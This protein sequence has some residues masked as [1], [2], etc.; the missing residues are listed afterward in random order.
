MDSFS[1]AVVPVLF[2]IVKGSVLGGPLFNMYVTPLASATSTDGVVV[3]QYSDESQACIEFTPNPDFS[4]QLQ[5]CLILAAWAVLTSACLTLNRVFLNVEKCD[6]LFT[7]TARQAPLVSTTPLQIG[8]S[9][10]HPSSEAKNL[11]VTLDSHLTMSTHVRQTCGPLPPQTN[12]Q[13]PSL[14]G[15][16]VGQVRDERSSFITP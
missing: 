11:G 5:C 3:R 10:I 7:S 9:V 13:D 16:P 1:S 2:G 12:Q 8:S 14:H 6:I 4:S 15:L